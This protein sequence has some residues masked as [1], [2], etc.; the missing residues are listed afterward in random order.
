LAVG[1]GD[2]EEHHVTGPLGERVRARILRLGSEAVIES[3]EACGLHLVP[4]NQRDPLRATT[5]GVGE[6]LSRAVTGGA[7][8]VVLG[9]GGS[10]TVDG[11]TGMAEAIGWRFFAESGEELPAGGGSLVGLARLEP[12]DQPLTARV[13]ALCDVRNPLVGELGAARVYGPQKGAGPDDII[14][15]DRG[16][17]LLADVIQSQLNMAVA[18]LPGAGA[19]GGLGAGAHAFLG[20]DLVSGADWMLERAGVGQLLASA[21]LVITAEGRYDAQS[22]MGKL[23]GKVLEKAGQVGVQALLVSGRVDGPLPHGVESVDGTG[24]QLAAEEITEL[25]AVGCRALAGR[26]RLADSGT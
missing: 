7:D 1:G 18:E 5:H 6:L 13:V 19:A 15:L 12:P 14:R 4:P 10:G 11:G 16:L 22:G 9:L 25:T 8:R 2:I 23:T 20:A 3:A 26:G 24:R 17:S 21:D